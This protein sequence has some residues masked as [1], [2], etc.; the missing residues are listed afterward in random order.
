MYIHHLLC[1]EQGRTFF[2][3]YT[4][5]FSS[6]WI[7]GFRVYDTC[8]FGARSSLKD[9]DSFYTNFRIFALKSS[10]IAAHFSQPE[11]KGSFSAHYFGSDLR[12]RDSIG[13]NATPIWITEVLGVEPTY[14]ST[15]I[16]KL[17]TSTPYHRPLNSSYLTININVASNGSVASVGEYQACTIYFLTMAEFHTSAFHSR[18]YSKWPIQSTNL[19]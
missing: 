1:Q 5:A 12:I 10:P 6:R 4:G 16:F 9:D 14:I 19:A 17:V 18:C 11:G 15:C 8:T 7:R 3:K 13:K 2:E